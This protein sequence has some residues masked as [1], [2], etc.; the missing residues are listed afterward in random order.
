MRSQFS[1]VA[2]LLATAAIPL[3]ASAQPLISRVA[4]VSELVVTAT[5]KTAA[6]SSTKTDT[7]LIETPQ[8]ISPASPIACS[9]RARAAG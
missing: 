7:P 1:L 5:G 3:A 8:L 6:T 4:T 2:A 9:S